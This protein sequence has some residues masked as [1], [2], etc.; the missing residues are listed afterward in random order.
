MGCKKK[1]QAQMNHQENIDAHLKPVAHIFGWM[2]Q[3]PQKQYKQRNMK[4][5][6]NVIGDIVCKIGKARKNSP[7]MPFNCV[8][9]MR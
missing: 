4:Y 1:M 7:L 6:K 9:F 2:A 3:K 5:G 8:Q